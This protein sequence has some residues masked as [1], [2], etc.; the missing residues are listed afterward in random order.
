MTTTRRNALAAGVCFLVAAASSIVALA[1]YQP[2]LGHPDYVTAGS[3]DSAIA[4]GALLEMVLALTVVGTSVFL[5]PVVRRQD[6]A[7]ALGY[8]GGR[9]LEAATIM[10]GIVSVLAVV[11]L[12]QDVGSSADSAVSQLVVRALVGVH[13]ATFLLGPGLVIGVNTFLL[14]WLMLRSSLVPR[15]I[16]VIGVVGGPLV[17]LSSTAVLLGAYDQL[18]TVAGLAALPVFVWEMSLA[19][20]LVAKG[21][22]SD[23]LVR[24][25]IAA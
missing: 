23:A 6:A 13:D 24:L 5:Y 25:G 21:F 15:W 17:L 10:V 8:V 18:S 16:A 11:T 4:V 19:I 12:R 14:A 3:A 22:R 7:L 1:L 2:V 9:I 20:Y